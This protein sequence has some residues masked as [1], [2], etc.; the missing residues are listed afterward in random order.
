[1]NACGCTNI[2]DQFNGSNFHIIRKALTVPMRDQVNNVSLHSVWN[3]S[4]MHLVNAY[5]RLLLR[6]VVSERRFTNFLSF[7]FN[8]E[9]IKLL[10][11]AFEV[12]SWI[13]SKAENPDFR[14]RVQVVTHVLRSACS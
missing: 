7:F 13:P 12:L 8:I 6:S 4:V 14:F 5:L 10:K 3:R 1:M 11:I 9:K 2:S